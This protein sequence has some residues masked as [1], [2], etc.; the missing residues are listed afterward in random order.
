MQKT[1][2]P[3]R[4]RPPPKPPEFRPTTQNTSRL[5]R[6]SLLDCG[7]DGHLVTST[8]TLHPDSVRPSSMVT[9]SFSGATAPITHVGDHRSGL[10]PN[11]HVCPASDF[12][13][14]A[15][16]P[17]LDTNPNYAVILTSTLALQLSNLPQLQVYRQ[18]QGPSRSPYIA[19]TST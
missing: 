18:S 3:H 2:F 13:L 6:P 16:G 14:V 10:F 11:C 7:A 8:R 19:I 9:Q 1:S 4:R 12:N 17:Y 5:H 15:V